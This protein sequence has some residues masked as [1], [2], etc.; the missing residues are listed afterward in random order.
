MSERE[1][2]KKSQ[3]KW[4]WSKQEQTQNDDH[5]RQTSVHLPEINHLLKPMNILFPSCVK[6]KPWEFSDQKF[7]WSVSPPD[8]LHCVC[9]VI[10]NSWWPMKN[11]RRLSTSTAT[12]E[13]VYMACLAQVWPITGE[14][15]GY[16]EPSWTEVWRKY[17]GGKRRWPPNPPSA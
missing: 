11:S 10:R 14:K 2:K 12:W 13:G 4:V 5:R 17:R 7:Q 16:K 15:V 3:N 8:A 1:K 9:G 6:I